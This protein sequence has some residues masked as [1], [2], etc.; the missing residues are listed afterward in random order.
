MQADL[1]YSV[2]TGEKPVAASA[3]LG[4]PIEVRQGQLAA[5]TVTIHDGRAAHKPFSLDREGFQLFPHPTAVVDFFDEDE[6][7]RVYY[8]EVERLVKDACGADRVVVFDHTLRSGDEADRQ[9][10]RL[11]EPVQI[12]HNDYTEWSGPQRVRDL[13]PANEAA[14]LLRHR[15]AVIQL[16]R[17]VR[18]PIGRDPLAICDAQ[19]MTAADLIP[20]ERRHPNRVGEIYHIAHNPRHRWYYFPQMRRDEVLIFKCYDAAIDGR[21]RFTAHG[22]FRDPNTKEMPHLAKA[23]KYA[24][25]HSSR[26]LDLRHILRSVHWPMGFVLGGWR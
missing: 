20:T 13:L 6:L 21:A 17:P 4:G 22:A 16:W 9:R 14:E 26:P 18:A 12:V 10:R 8:P 15:F 5:D 24:P 11:R 2:R 19:S 23:S 7:R 25:W 3:T 1:N